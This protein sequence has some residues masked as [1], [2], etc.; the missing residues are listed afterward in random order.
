VTALPEHTVAEEIGSVRGEERGFFPFFVIYWD[1]KKK[2]GFPFG[3]LKSSLSLP[4]SVI[5]LRLVDDYIV[6]PS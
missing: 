1:E 4:P 2:T 5:L 6:I 3:I